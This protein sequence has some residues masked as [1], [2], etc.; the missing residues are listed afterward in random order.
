[1]KLG[2]EQ[3]VKLSAYPLLHRLRLHTSPCRASRSTTLWIRKEEA[4][5][6]SLIEAKTMQQ[7]PDT[8]M[9][10]NERERQTDRDRDGRVGRIRENG[11]REGERTEEEERERK[12]RR[13]EENGGRKDPAK[14][15]GYICRWRLIILTEFRQ[16]RNWKAHSCW[17][18]IRPL[19]A[20]YQKALINN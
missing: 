1:M 9:R 17:Y 12:K 2:E 20:L 13:G 3:T 14:R 4:E 19:F 8:F 10:V 7:W 6:V 11:R 18:Q 16:T 15:R 5:S